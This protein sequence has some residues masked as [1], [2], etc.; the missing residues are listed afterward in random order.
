MPR[1][2]EGPLPLSAIQGRRVYLL[3][4]R[5]PNR[6]PITSLDLTTQWPEPVLEVRL[7]EAS[8]SSSLKAAEA[9]D[10]QPLAV[11]GD[12]PPSAAVEPFALEERAGLWRISVDSVPAFSSVG[13]ELLSATGAEGGLYAEIAPEIDRRRSVGELLWLIE[14]HYQFQ[15]GDD[16][17][18][19][20][21]LLSL[22][23]DRAMRQVTVRPVAGQPAAQPARLQIRHGRGA[24]LPGLLRTRGYLV[25]QGRSG[26]RYTAPVMLETTH[27]IDVQFGLFGSPLRPGLSV[28]ARTPRNEQP[29]NHRM[30]RTKPAQATKPRRSS[31]CSPNMTCDGLGGSDR[32]CHALR[33]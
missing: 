12:I 32:S 11:T 26:T 33:G 17:S 5:N 13:I 24:R 7:A 15:M 8:A 22:E 21:V 2:N 23:F 31:V 18:T 6:F 1:P 20:A 29:P 27:N 14:G 9:W 4:I 16:T 3:T 30:Q 19:R 28:T 25:S 10:P